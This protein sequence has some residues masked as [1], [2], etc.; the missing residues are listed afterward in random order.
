MEAFEIKNWVKKKLCKN[1]MWQ[2]RGEYVYLNDQNT[3]IKVKVKE[4]HTDI[5]NEVYEL[6]E[7]HDW[8]VYTP[9]KKIWYHHIYRLY[10]PETLPGW[11]L[12]DVISEY[13]WEVFVKKD[14]ELY[15]ST[16]THCTIK[17]FHIQTISHDDYYGIDK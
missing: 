6:F 15:N 16:E 2:D 11:E 14:R 13:N 9:P 12:Y 10:C 7:D 8:Q 1:K 5:Y 4:A 3:W 17:Y